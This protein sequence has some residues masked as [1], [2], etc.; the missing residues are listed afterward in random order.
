MVKSA[1]NTEGYFDLSNVDAE[2]LSTTSIKN[3]RLFGS[4]EVGDTRRYEFVITPNVDFLASPLPLMKNTELKLSFDRAPCATALLATGD[5]KTECTEIV[6]ADVYAT[7]EWISSPTLRDIFETVDIQPII[8]QYEEC[9]VIIKNLNN[10]STDLRFDNLKGGN[11]PSYVFMGLIPQKNLSGSFAHSSTKFT[12]NNVIEANITLDGNSVDVY[13]IEIKDG[14]AIYPM[15][16]FIKDTGRLYNNE[17]GSTLHVAEY[18][19]N[20]L[21][22]HK[23]EANISPKGWIGVS[24][25]LSESFT[26]QEPMAMVIWIVSSAVISIDKYHQVEKINL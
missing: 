12:S 11:V 21:W 14:S 25:K 9:D 26:E 20:F 4:S 19:Y 22:S 3:N 2:D 10:G 6:L 18:N 24:V 23:F 16:K 8:Y 7:T 13:P 17:C 15:H 1:F 5:I